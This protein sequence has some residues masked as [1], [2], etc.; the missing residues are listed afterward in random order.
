LIRPCWNATTVSIL[1]AK[2]KRGEGG[3]RKFAL[4]VQGLIN[5]AVSNCSRVAGFV[6][7][8]FYFHSGDEDCHRGSREGKA[9]RQRRPHSISIPENVLAVSDRVI[10]C[11]VIEFRP[12]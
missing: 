8:G 6:P 12:V 2:I 11:V 10:F 5:K 7:G 9:A 4:S 3:A 1:A